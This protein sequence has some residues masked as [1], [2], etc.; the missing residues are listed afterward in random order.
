MKRI[1]MVV[2][3]ALVMVAMLAATAAP[4]FAKITCVNPAGQSPQG[5][6]NG[7]ALAFE[8]PAGHQPPGQN[9]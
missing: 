2:T 5:N 9:M 1:V 8:N 3:V 6:C 4:A 7:T